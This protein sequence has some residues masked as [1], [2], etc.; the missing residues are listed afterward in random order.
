MVTQIG[1]SKIEIERPTQNIGDSRVVTRQME[2]WNPTERE[3]ANGRFTGP[4][5]PEACEARGV[6]TNPGKGDQTVTV[7]SRA[8]VAWKC[9]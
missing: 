7:E 6:V 1:K 4:S 2:V 8:W 9:K 5:C 3:G